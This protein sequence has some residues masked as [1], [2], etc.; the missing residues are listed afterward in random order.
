L[1]RLVS[2]LC[3]QDPEM[4]GLLALMLLTDARRAARTAADGSLVLLADQ[5]RSR[6]DSAK[7]A[8]GMRVLDRAVQVRRPGSYQLQ[9]AIAA[10]HA[11]AADAADTDWAQIAL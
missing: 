9:A 4:L 5:D 6:W 1:A 2:G 7:T 11:A 3:P 10:C 8:E